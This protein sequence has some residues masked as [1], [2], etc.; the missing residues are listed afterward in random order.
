MDGAAAGGRADV[1]EP[2]CSN[3]GERGKKDLARILGLGLAKKVLRDRTSDWGKHCATSKKGISLFT[4]NGR[5]NSCYE[6][7]RMEE[8]SGGGIRP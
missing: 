2:R 7:E 3:L 6:Q 8:E 4:T 5:A 1:R